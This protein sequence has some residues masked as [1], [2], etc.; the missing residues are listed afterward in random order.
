LP[1]AKNRKIQQVEKVGGKKMESFDNANLLWL[2]PLLL[3]ELAWKA[4]A[5]WRAARLSQKGWFVVLLVL[6]TA[7]ILP[8]IY[9]MTHNENSK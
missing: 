9:L 1:E 5:M 3:W 6:N 4:M 7:G 8:I 2:V